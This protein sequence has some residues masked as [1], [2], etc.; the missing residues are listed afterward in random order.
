MGCQLFSKAMA[1]YPNNRKSQNR[2]VCFAGDHNLVQ[3][4]RNL[5]KAKAMKHFLLVDL[6]KQALQEGS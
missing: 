2:E 4:L 5:A 6:C 3:L 1:C